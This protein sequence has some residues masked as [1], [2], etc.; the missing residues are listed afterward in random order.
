MNAVNND[1]TPSVVSKAVFIMCCTC[2]YTKTDFE[3]L[4]R[5]H[6]IIWNNQEESI[7]NIQVIILNLATPGLREEFFTRAIP[8]GDR[9]LNPGCVG[10]SDAMVFILKV[11]EDLIRSN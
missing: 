5:Q 1:G 2:E 6:A 10:T 11:V 3:E 7:Q 4:K 9:Q 8:P